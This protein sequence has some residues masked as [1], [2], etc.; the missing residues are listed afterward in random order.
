MGTK[1]TKEYDLNKEEILGVGICNIQK[2]EFQ[3]IILKDLLNGVKRVVVA[4]NPEKI[5]KAKNDNTL[6]SILNQADYQI[7]DGI[8]IVLASRILKGKIKERITGISCLEMICE[9]ASKNNFSIFLYGS[10][11]EVVIQTKKNLESQYKNLNIVGYINGYSNDHIV[12]EQIQK[13]NPDIVFV[14][15]GSPKQEYWIYENKDKINAK[16]FLGVGGSFDVI[17]KEVKRA[18]LFLQEKGLEWLYRAFK[19]PKRILRQGYLLRYIFNVIFTRLSN[20]PTN[21][22][23]SIKKTEIDI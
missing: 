17:S 4:I 19:Q 22:K 9:I 15:L 1:M 3:N 6:F 20:M 10:R 14:A 23:E 7:A 11:Q 13:S 5:I 2:D 16:V 12:I 8:G 18:P 21:K